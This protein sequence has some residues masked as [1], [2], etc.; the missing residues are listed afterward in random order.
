MAKE[1]IGIGEPLLRP[2]M[3]GYDSWSEIGVTWSIPFQL[4][5]D[6]AGSAY[7]FLDNDLFPWEAVLNSLFSGVGFDP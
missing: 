5:S 2:P 7:H 4:K 6:C 3:S 1:E